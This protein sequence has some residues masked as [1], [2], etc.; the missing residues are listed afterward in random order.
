MKAELGDEWEEAVVL[1]TTTFPAS[2]A[3]K[4][5]GGVKKEM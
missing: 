3:K 2:E 1:N 4:A 5:S